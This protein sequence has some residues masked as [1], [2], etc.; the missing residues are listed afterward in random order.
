M[1]KPPLHLVRFAALGLWLAVAFAAPA[2]AEGNCPPGYYPIGGGT[3]GWVGCAPMGPMP[4]ESGED[5]PVDEPAR[6][7]GPPPVEAYMAVAFHWDSPEIWATAGQRSKA[8]AEGMVSR[9]CEQAMGS[10]CNWLAGINNVTIA[11]AADENGILFGANAVAS[12]ELAKGKA[13]ARCEEFSFN[14]RIVRVFNPILIPNGASPAH[15]F[16]ATWLP[17]D[18]I[19]RHR[20]AAIAAPEDKAAEPWLGKSWL[21]SGANGFAAANGQAVAACE[22]ATGGKCKALL[23]SASGPIGLVYT[24]TGQVELASLPASGDPHERVRLICRKAADGCALVAQLDTAGSGVR[25]V[26]TFKIEQPLRGFHAV[27]RA[28]KGP[29]GIAV[30]AGH[31]DRATAEAAALTQCRASGAIACAIDTGGLGDHGLGPFMA[32]YIDQAGGTLYEYGITAANARARAEAWCVRDKL[33]CRPVGVWD[34]SASLRQ[35]QPIRQR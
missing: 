25:V 8:V 3:A 26:D 7:A 1:F 24:G 6:P 19:R 15:D 31:G 21:V 22:K 10:E 5:Q 28:T 20:V 29:D 18:Q 11:L 17:A 14:C 12:A 13:I 32:A 2:R 33:T 30:S 4:E 16:S 35:W 9:A 27:A 34:L 23:A